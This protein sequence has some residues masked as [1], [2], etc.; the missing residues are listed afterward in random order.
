MPCWKLLENTVF[1][2]RARTFAILFT[3]STSLALSS[4]VKFSRGRPRDVQNVNAS[5]SRECN[6]I[7]IISSLNFFESEFRKFRKFRGIRFSGVRVWGEER[8]HS[9]KTVNGAFCS[10]SIISWPGQNLRETN[11]SIGRRD[12]LLFD[13]LRFPRFSFFF[14]HEPVD[15]LMENK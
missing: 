1:V 7:A 4:R 15:R 6:E 14:F 13:E 9:D 3:V 2:T 11:R 5:R 12:W 10:S 8:Y